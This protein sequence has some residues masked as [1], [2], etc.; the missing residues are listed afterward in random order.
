MK[1]FAFLLAAASCAALPL[2][3]QTPLRVGQ[4]L[5]G[6][7]DASDPQMQEGPHYDAYVL[8]GQPGQRVVVRMRSDD[9]DAY[10]HYGRAGADGWEATLVD[11]DGG[12]GLNARLTLTLDAEGGYELRASSLDEEE[13][14]TYEISLMERRDVPPG[15]IRVGQTVRGELTQTD[16]EGEGP[17]DHYLITGRQGETVTVFAESND[18]DAY[19]VLASDNEGELWEV[20][21]DDD[22]GVATDAQMVVAFQESGEYHVVVRSFGGD[23]AGAYTLRVQEG[24]AEP[25]VEEEEMMEDV[26]FSGEGVDVPELAFQ[27]ETVGPVT[28]G[29]DIRGELRGEVTEEDWTMFYH[30]Y[31]YRATAG[32]RLVIRVSS[33]ELDSYVFIGRGQGEA[34]ELLSE[35]DDDGEDL[36]SLLEFQVP[37]AGEYVI[38]VS[39]A[40]PDQTGPYVLRVERQD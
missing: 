23:G 40:A 34:F 36:D 10:L 7:L 17:E 26:D 32:E 9:F 19:L 1:G 22:S 30:D 15:R 2:S 25:V 4:T 37:A 38:R 14:G 12:D 6:T 29:R 20:N 31:T 18:F 11:D 28:L 21:A 33:E 8:R 3:A 27:G 16:Y 39:T 35:N 24:A 5:T 13:L